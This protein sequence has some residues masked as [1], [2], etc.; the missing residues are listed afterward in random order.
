MSTINGFNSYASNSY[1]SN[2]GTSSSLAAKQSSYSSDASNDTPSGATSFQSAAR[3][4]FSQKALDLSAQND[5]EV[6]NAYALQMQRVE[7]NAELS[8]MT[9]LQSKDFVSENQETMKQQVINEGYVR[10]GNLSLV[11]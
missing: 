7:E 9:Q 6:A 4:T 2:T 10:G 5:Y 11:G 3:V 1:L 8:N